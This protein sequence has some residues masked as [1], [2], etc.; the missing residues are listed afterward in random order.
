LDT[1]Y[2]INNLTHI[3]STSGDSS[4]IK[5]AFYRNQGQNTLIF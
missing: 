2:N 4:L 1:E 3:I 5:S